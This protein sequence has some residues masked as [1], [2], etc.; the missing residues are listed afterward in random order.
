MVVLFRF[1]HEEEP[2]RVLG[3]KILPVAL[4]AFSRLISVMDLHMI[5]VEKVT[6]RLYEVF[7]V[8]GVFVL[9]LLRFHLPLGTVLAL[10]KLATLQ[11]LLGVLMQHRLSSPKL[12]R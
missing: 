4:L 2:L 6:S 8:V 7:Y 9:S 12:T 11:S 10:E 1:S 5:C 3:D